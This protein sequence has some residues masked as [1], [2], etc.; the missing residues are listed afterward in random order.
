MDKA[1]KEFHKSRRKEFSKLIG[2]DSIAIIF[3]ST[4]QNKSFDGDF[5]F[6]QFKNF[7]YLTGF[8]EPNAA[9]IIAPSSIK[10]RN[11]EGA[12]AAS[13]ILF[14]QKK[15]PLMETWNGKRLGFDNVSQELGIEGA[16]E[17]FDLKK[18]LSSISFSKFRKLYINFSEVIKINGEMNEIITQ[19]INKLNTISS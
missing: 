17:N 7:Y 1:Q 3:G 16:M 15:D 5:D 14:V 13:E 10:T 4:H 19:F 11:D 18:T 2:R 9:F 6:K 12:K 8:T